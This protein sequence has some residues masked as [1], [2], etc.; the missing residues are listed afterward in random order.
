MTLNAIQMRGKSCAEHC[1]QVRTCLVGERG[2]T[3]MPKLSPA[4]KLGPLLISAYTS[5]QLYIR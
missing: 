2:S 5:L 4:C 1:E 3:G